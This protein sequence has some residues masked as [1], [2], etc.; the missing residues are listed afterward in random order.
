[1]GI[2]TAI[3]NG[4]RIEATAYIDTGADVSIV[5][6]RYSTPCEQKKRTHYTASSA[7]CNHPPGK[8]QN[9][10]HRRLAIADN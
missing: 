4:R 3:L 1:M 7:R 10:V 2:L 6:A 8:A 9:D 5:S